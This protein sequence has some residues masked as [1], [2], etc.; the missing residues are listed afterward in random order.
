MKEVKVGIIGFGTVGTGVA[1]CLLE[2]RSVMEKRTGIKIKLHKIS[3]IDITTSR[4]INL[5]D[6][7]LTTDTDKLIDESDIVVELVGGIEVAKKIILSALKK[8]KPVVTA[9]KALLAEKGKDI[10]KAAEKSNADVYYEASVAGGIPIIKSLREG[11]AGNKINKILGILNGTCN[12]IL[13]K[14]END[15]QNFID[16]LNKASDL[17]Y[18]EADPTLD[19]D[20]FDTAHKTSILASLAYG[21]L[22]DMKDIHIEGIRN[23]ALMDINFAKDLG[24]RIKLMGIIKKKHDNVEV[25]VHPTMIPCNT[26]M[27]NISDV[28][29][30]VF[31]EGNPVGSTLF[32]GQGAGMEATSSAVVADIVDVALNIKKNSTQRIPAFKEAKQFNSLISMDCIKSRYYIRI[33]VIEKPGVIAKISKILGDE[34][35]SISSILQREKEVSSEFVP[36]VIITHKTH[37]K[38]MLSAI[39]KM[40]NLDEIK[41]KIK[42][43]RIEDI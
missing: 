14:M 27:A 7:V 34:N 32:Y 1:S 4:N 28:N 42:L 31:I 36:V 30:G 37:E 25:R 9:N 16:A 3:D 41:E 22:I 39:D 19:I 26:I 6:G 23:I 20:G 17:G 33:Q 13:T 21:E 43:I 2:N 8:G 24:Y 40:Q 11:L 12:Y 38:N 5:P 18:A 29:N 10:F 15:S 35:I